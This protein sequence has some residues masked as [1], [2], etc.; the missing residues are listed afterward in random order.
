MAGPVDSVAIVD[1]VE[2]VEQKIDR[3][4]KQPESTRRHGVELLIVKLEC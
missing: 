1:R 2:K 4:H 3:R